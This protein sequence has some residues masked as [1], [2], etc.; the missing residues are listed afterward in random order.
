[1]ILLRWSRGVLMLGALFLTLSA[2]PV[3]AQPATEASSTA[4]ATKTG[5]Y[6]KLLAKTKRLEALRYRNLWIAYGIIWFLVFGFTYRTWKRSE[7][8]MISLED[9]KRRLADLEAKDG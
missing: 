7:E 9:L 6:G 8:T 3:L 1:M 4:T 5:K 2:A